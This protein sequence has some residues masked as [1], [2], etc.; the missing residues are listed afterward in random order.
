[1]RQR[2]DQTLIILLNNIRIRYIIKNNQTISKFRF[3]DISDPDY[4]NIT[5]HVW[6]ENAPIEKHNQKMLDL[7][8]GPEFQIPLF[9]KIPENVCNT[10]IN[11][12]YTFRKRNPAGSAE[13]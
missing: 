12:I 7:L 5:F 6:T 1:M 11:K 3:I 10:I 13:K 9:D 2:G 4:S 8:T